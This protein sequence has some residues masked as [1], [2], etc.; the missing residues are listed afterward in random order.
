MSGDVMTRR[1]L[2]WRIPV[3]DRPHP[4]GPGQVLLVACQFGPEEVQVWT[5][6]DH[7]PLAAEQRQAIVIGTGQRVPDG[8]EHLG[9]VIAAGGVLVWHAYA[10][11]SR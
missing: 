1:V 7:E 9:S 11:V 5:E 10:E 2:K 6:E 8:Y 4:I 3:D